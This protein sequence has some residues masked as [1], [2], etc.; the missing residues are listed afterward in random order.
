MT[1]QGL[2]RA[3]I[4]QVAKD[5]AFLPQALAI[6]GSTPLVADAPHSADTWRKLHENLKAKAELQEHDD[7]HQRS[8]N[9]ALS[10]SFDELGR[11][12]RG[13]FLKLAVLSKG[14]AASKSML[15]HLWEQVFF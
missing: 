14:T 3:T 13:R 10:V 8:L 12:Q 1:N 2:A 15:S 4:D 5:C 11:E 7:V 9:S 6:V